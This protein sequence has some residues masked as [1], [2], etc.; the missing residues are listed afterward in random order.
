MLFIVARSADPPGKVKPIQSNKVYMCK[1]RFI[2]W[3]VFDCAHNFVFY[4]FKGNRR[5]S[6]IFTEN[7]PDVMHHASRNA[8]SLQIRTDRG[9]L[10]LGGCF[11]DPPEASGI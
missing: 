5:G 3:V 4:D 6:K 9:F 2:I 1:D 7:H 11:L 8:V 10:T